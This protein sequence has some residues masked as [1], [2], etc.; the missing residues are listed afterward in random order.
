VVTEDNN[1]KD[2][3]LAQDTDEELLAKPG[4]LIKRKARDSAKATGAPT[5]ALLDDLT[6]P[7]YKASDPAKILH[8]CI[9]EDCPAY[10]SRRHLSRVTRHAQTC[11]LLSSE[12]QAKAKAYV[13]SRAPSTKLAEAAGDGE[14]EKASVEEPAMKKPKVMD[15]YV[16][17]GVKTQAKRRH[18]QL[19]LDITI[20]FS[21][22]PTFLSD[23][24]RWR[25]VFKTAD[26]T[27]K[28]P[29]RQRL[30]EEMIPGEAEEVLEKQLK[31]LKNEHYL[32]ISFDGGTKKGE[33]HYT[34]HILTPDRNVY[35]M[36]TRHA[37][38][39]SHT[40]EWIKDLAM[41]V[42]GVGKMRLILIG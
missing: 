33:A 28:L 36:E 14:L 31:L 13:K 4:E 19:D 37:T 27:Y 24:V 15:V 2:E 41:K 34:V 1:N 38:D 21:T 30:E 25:N 35:L 11:K 20:L 22:L 18:E 26:P 42:S 40:G 32:T 6:W 5:K 39:E 16:K 17:K 9:A 29:T 23:S 3:E 8:K 10:W 7:C 12:L